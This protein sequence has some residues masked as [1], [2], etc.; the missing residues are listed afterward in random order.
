MALDFFIFTGFGQGL[1]LLYLFQ[2]IADNFGI[3]AM[4]IYPFWM[5]TLMPCFY[6]SIIIYKRVLIFKSSL[7]SFHSRKRLRTNYPKLGLTN[8]TTKTTILQNPFHLLHIII[9]RFSYLP[10]PEHR[11]VISLLY[12]GMHRHPLN[13]PPLLHTRIP[14]LRHN[15]MI[16][17][18][19]PQQLPSLNQPLCYRN[20]LLTGLRIT[21]R[22]IMN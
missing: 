21:R 4:R 1:Y 15:N 19:N 9:I 2:I 14:V 17:N 11:S 12:K 20:I 8:H 10:P 5:F 22:V 16:M 3:S 7:T 18:F 13:H 6:L